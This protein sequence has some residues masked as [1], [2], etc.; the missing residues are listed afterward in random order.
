MVIDGHY[1]ALTRAFSEAGAKSKAA[2]ATKS[3]D[4]NSY[5]LHVD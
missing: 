2:N 5:S 3:V 4:T 1:S